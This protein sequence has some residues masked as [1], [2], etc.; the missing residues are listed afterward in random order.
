MRGYFRIT[1]EISE[2]QNY[3]FSGFTEL[4]LIK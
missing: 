4:G 3:N 1:V 2:I